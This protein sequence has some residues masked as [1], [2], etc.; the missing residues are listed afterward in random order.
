TAA[1]LRV[2]A[3]FP[4]DLALAIVKK[5]SW[6][7]LIS[8]LE[9]LLALPQFKEPDSKPRNEL[10]N[11]LYQLL[12]V[13]RQYF[14]PYDRSQLSLSVVHHVQ[15]ALNQR[16][17]ETYPDLITKLNPKNFFAKL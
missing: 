17:D 10:L 2:L 8:S 1:N 11:H 6:D 12:P 16:F 14:S 5:F 9:E 15:E 13:N 7:K 4:S 3:D